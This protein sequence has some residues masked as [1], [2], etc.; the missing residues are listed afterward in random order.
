[1]TMNQFMR[2]HG[3]VLRSH[4]HC[5]RQRTSRASQFTCSISTVRMSDTAAS[6][7]GV[8]YYWCGDL[9]ELV[10]WVK[11][12]G[13]SRRVVIMSYTRT[14]QQQQPATDPPT[15][16]TDTDIDR[17]ARP[18]TSASTYIYILK[19]PLLPLLYLLDLGLV[20]EAAL[21]GPRRHLAC[22]GILSRW[23]CGSGWN[24]GCGGAG[25]GIRMN[26]Q[27]TLMNWSTDRPSVYPHPHHTYNAPSFGL[28]CAPGSSTASWMPRRWPASAIIRPSWPPP[29]TPTRRPSISFPFWRLLACSLLVPVDGGGDEMGVL[30]NACVVLAPLVATAVQQQ[31]Q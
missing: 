30:V 17:L 27:D 1:M 31:A 24:A 5:H 26:V 10:G 15:A 16:D 13:F 6:S 18:H 11:E 14:Q 25:V 22:G 29:N 3:C 8:L 21:D 20:A 19:P 7:L 23:E 12:G 28:K 2:C 9:G 4:V